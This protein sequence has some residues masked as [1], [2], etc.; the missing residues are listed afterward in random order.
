[1]EPRRKRAHGRQALTR[2]E[3]P[4]PDSIFNT[5]SDLIA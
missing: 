5:G 1:M 3:P 2:G 4:A